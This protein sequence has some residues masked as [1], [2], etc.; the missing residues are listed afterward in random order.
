MKLFDLHYLYTLPS[1]PENPSYYFNILSQQE[2]FKIELSKETPI[3]FTL[4]HDRK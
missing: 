1:V 3:V 4:I 2:I